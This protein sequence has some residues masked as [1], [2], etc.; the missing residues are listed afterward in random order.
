MAVDNTTT[1]TVAWFSGGT[2]GHSYEFLNRIETSGG[3]TYDKSLRFEV[4]DK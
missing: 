1:Y 3:R 2:S 4:W